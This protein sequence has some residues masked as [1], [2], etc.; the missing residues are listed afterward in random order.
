MS[1]TADTR[2]ISPRWRLRVDSTH[3]SIAA[4]KVSLREKSRRSIQD[5]L[6]MPVESGR[7]HHRCSPWPPTSRRRARRLTTLGGPPVFPCP[8]GARSYT[9]YRR[10][11][12]CTP[13][14]VLAGLGLHSRPAGPT[15]T[16]RNS[17]QTRRNRTYQTSY[18]ATTSRRHAHA[19]TSQVPVHNQAPT[20]RPPVAC[21]S[22]ACASRRRESVLKTVA[23]KGP[24]VRIPPSPPSPFNP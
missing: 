10:P 18:T 5:F 21:V 8:P 24:G 20:R 6:T 2:P 13:R 3:S 11:R 22:S 12:T 17:A 4:A 9:P 1:P 7:N 23:P 14:P 16:R 15:S 19:S